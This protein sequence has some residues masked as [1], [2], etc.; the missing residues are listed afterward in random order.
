MLPYSKL[1]KDIT[2]IVG[3]PDTLRLYIHLLICSNYKSEISVKGIVIRRNQIAESLDR[4]AEELKMSK[5]KVRRSLAF[6]E[7]NGFIVIDRS[8]GFNV[9]TLVTDEECAE[10]RSSC[11]IDI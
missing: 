4:L 6:L 3:K 11:K 8:R 9:I 5:S 10:P 1:R 7:T 2:K